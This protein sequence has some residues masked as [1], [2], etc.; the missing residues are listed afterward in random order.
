MKLLLDQNLSR[1]LV[2]RLEPKYPGTRHVTNIGAETEDDHV[3]WAR[4]RRDGFVFVTKDRDFEDATRHQGPPPKVILLLV[5][6]TRTRL[7]LSVL[8]RNEE[9]IKGFETSGERILRLK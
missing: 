4:C 6:N 8:T 5:G 3:V 1:N 2:A 7:A 9:R